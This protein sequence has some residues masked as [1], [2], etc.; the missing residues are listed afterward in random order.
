[1]ETYTFYLLFS[2]D[3]T[4][5]EQASVSSMEVDET[6]DEKANNS[7]LIE[8]KS[9]EGEV[10]EGEK[11]EEVD[12]TKLSEANENKV[13]DLGSLEIKSPS[14]ENFNMDIMEVE[15]D[16]TQA[17][18]VKEEK[19]SIEV[20]PTLSEELK[21]KEDDKK[22]EVDQKIEDIKTEKDKKD[23]ENISLLQAKVT[24]QDVDMKGLKVESKDSKD[25]IKDIAIN[26]DNVKKED[27]SRCSIGADLKNGVKEENLKDFPKK[28]Y[29]VK[30]EKDMKM[31]NGIKK[32]ETVYNFSFDAEKFIVEQ[33][34]KMGLEQTNM[35][36]INDINCQLKSVE[37]KY[38]IIH[39]P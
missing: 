11:N 12:K 28:Q 26:N 38:Y 13:K 19:I 34:S 30:D 21:L 27:I 14:Q 2:S 24:K 22:D 32:S 1:M 37:S 39:F 35:K 31:V 9:L 23:A 36:K 16:N 25:D 10:I 17:K 8:S 5:K 15:E 6:E 20:D 3:K 18:G 29:G 7:K 33:I 4:D